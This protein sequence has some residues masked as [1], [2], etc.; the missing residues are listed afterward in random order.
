LF[1][2]NGDKQIDVWSYYL[3]GVEVYREVD[4]NFDKKP[5]QFRWLNSAGMKWGVDNVGD[6]KIHEWRMISAEEVSQEILQAV[7]AKDFD[8]LQAL[9][10][11]D[12]DMQ[13]L[14]LPAN[15][16]TRLQGL[17]KSAQATFQ[18]TVAKLTGLNTTTHW[19]HLETSAPQ[20]IPADALGGK[21]DMIKYAR[22]TILCETGTKNEWLQT[23]E[24]VRVGAAWRIVEAPTQGDGSN[25]AGQGMVINPQ[26]QGLFAELEK[27]GKQEPG[28]TAKSAD[29]VKYNLERG[30]L[31]VKIV[32]NVDDKDRE[33]WIRQIADC[34][35]SAAQNSTEKETEAYDR[36]KGLADQYKKAVPEA[37]VT[38]YIV[39]REVQAYNSMVLAKA[40][41]PPDV[42]AE[43]AKRLEDFVNQYPKAEDTPEAMWQLAVMS[44]FFDKKEDAK[45][46]YKR[47]VTGFPTHG[48]KQR[49]EGAGL[50]LE[51]QGQ[52]LEL[53]ATPLN[54]GSFDLSALKGKFVVVYCWTSQDQQRCANDFASLKLLASNHSS[55]LEIVCVNCDASAQV[56]GNFLQKLPAPGTQLFQEGGLDGKFATHYGLIVLPAI[57]VLDKDGKVLNQTLQQAAGIEAELK[58]ATK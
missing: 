24:L 25:A 4:T 56:A 48:Y 3:D 12:A 54:G 18:A 15:E 46:W 27:L 38:A 31:L 50:R 13:G 39:F 8:R 41:N 34:L 30:D 44:E 16:V 19:L 52:P 10:L 33:Q 36:L 6:G 47:I 1:D 11:S 57:F 58:K 14:G 43:C 42:Q 35:S 20:C 32:K 26:L 53:T 45:N 51:L 55:D 40:K 28:P 17:R 22:G 5:D 49:A 7:I 2:T 29:V 21:Y 37:P 9:F 23:G